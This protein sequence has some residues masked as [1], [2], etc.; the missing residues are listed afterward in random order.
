MSRIALFILVMINYRDNEKWFKK[1]GKKRAS[2]MDWT[3]FYIPY[4][5]FCAFETIH[6]LYVNYLYKL[7]KLHSNVSYNEYKKGGQFVQE[8]SI[9]DSN[10]EIKNPQ[11][12]PYNNP[13]TESSQ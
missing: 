11:I 13:S 10:T 2:S 9:R 12:F 8:V 3:L 5:Y 7:I 4:I 1:E 6:L